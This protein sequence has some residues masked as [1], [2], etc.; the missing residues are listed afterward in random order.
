[1]IIIYILGLGVTLFMFLHLSML[2]MTAMLYRKEL[3]Y[4]GH[5]VTF[6][7]HLAGVLILGVSLVFMTGLILNNYYI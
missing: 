1:M 4:K 5:K 2:F 7:I 3:N 6:L